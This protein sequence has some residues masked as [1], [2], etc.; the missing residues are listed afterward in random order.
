M[1][2]VAYIPIKD[3]FIL[4]S[5]RDEHRGRAAASPPNQI[6][7]GGNKVLMPVDGKAGGTWIALRE[8]GVALVLLN[9]AFENHERKPSYRHSRGIIIPQMMREDQPSLAFEA[10]NLQ[11]IEPFTLLAI[12]GLPS[13][14]RWDGNALQRENPD[15]GKT[16]CIS[17]ATLYHQQQQA[18]R[19]GWFFDFVS[20]DSSI[21]AK[22][23]LHWLS[24]GGYGPQ[25]TDIVLNRQD[26]IRTVSS[27]VVSVCKKERQMLYR[28]YLSAQTAEASFSKQDI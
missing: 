14:W 7:L 8:D 23:L 12:H 22:G 28:D 21:H 10:M 18:I 1:C 11:D 24:T 19:A 5:N 9:G 4:G 2:F 25:D 3:G 27:T 20:M 17:S 26:G 6:T 15:P 16:L 13:L